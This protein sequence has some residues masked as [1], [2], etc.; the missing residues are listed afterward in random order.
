MV[1]QEKRVEPRNARRSEGAKA[2]AEME[3]GRVRAMTICTTMYS[4]DTM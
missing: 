2:V 3:S 1:V 4:V